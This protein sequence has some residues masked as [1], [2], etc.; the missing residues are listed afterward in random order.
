LS[1]WATTSRQL[2]SLQHRAPASD[3]RSLSEL[4]DAVNHPDEDQ[5]FA[6]F[7]NADEDDDQ[8]G[9]RRFFGK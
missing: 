8:K 9:I 1:T 7:G 5:A 3:E 4:H 6:E 2:R